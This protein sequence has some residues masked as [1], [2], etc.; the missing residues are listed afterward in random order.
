[1]GVRDV[2]TFIVTV[3]VGA[4]LAGLVTAPVI[5]AKADGNVHAYWSASYKL[6]IL[7]IQAHKSRWVDGG[8][9]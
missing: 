9:N 3:G 8:M 7:I 2:M 5:G 1:M 6:Q 4:G